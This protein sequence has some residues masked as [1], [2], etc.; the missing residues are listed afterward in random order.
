MTDDDRR[1]LNDASRLI[2]DVISDLS[3]RMVIGGPKVLL[4]WL[5]YLRDE[6]ANKQQ[7][8]DAA[9]EAQLYNDAQQ[10]SSYLVGCATLGIRLGDIGKSF[11]EAMTDIQKNDSRPR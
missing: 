5:T 9:I 6:V 10:L 4:E 11:S 3:R 7:A 8:R 2:G 1:I